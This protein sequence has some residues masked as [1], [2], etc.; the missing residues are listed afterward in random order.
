[1]LAP[2]LET[3]GPDLLLWIKVVPG[4]SRSQ[5]AGV[6]GDRLKIRIAAAPEQ[7]K[8]NQAICELIARQL[9]IKSS[10]ITIESGHTSPEK[11]V[12][13]AQIGEDNLCK[14]WK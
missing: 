1:M 4:A 3:H 8:A 9:K 14:L 7:G 2:R 13:I 5:I 11:I 10:Q 6:L 12:R